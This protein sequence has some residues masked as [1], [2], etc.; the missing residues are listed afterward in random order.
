MLVHGK[1]FILYFKPYVSLEQVY[2]MYTQYVC[3]FS[4]QCAGLRYRHCGLLRH[5]HV[6]TRLDFQYTLSM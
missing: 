4:L 6:P 2:S 1:I 3:V 5:V